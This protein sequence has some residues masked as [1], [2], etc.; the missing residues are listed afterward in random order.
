MA[1]FAVQML[2]QTPKPVPRGGADA[3]GNAEMLLAISSASSRDVE[4]DF[5][6]SFENMMEGKCPTGWTCSGPA[7]VCFPG[8]SS[9]PC[10]PYPGIKGH[11]GKQFLDVGNDFGTATAL[12]PMFKLP[13]DIDRICF[14]RC[15]GADEGS[16]LYLNLVSNGEQI[17]IAENGQD[18]DVFSVQCC[19][20]LAQHAGKEV[21]IHIR[22]AQSSGWGKVLIDDIRLLDSSGRDIGPKAP[23]RPQQSCG[24]VQEDVHY[25]GVTSL[26]SSMTL[27]AEDCCALCEKEPRCGAWAW[28]KIKNNWLTNKCFLKEL[29]PG[30]VPKQ[31]TWDGVVSGLPVK[32][33]RLI[34]APLFR[35]TEYKEQQGAAFTPGDEI[36]LYGIGSS[37]MLW[38]NWL[39]ELH[40]VLSRLGY[41][42]PAV[43]AKVKPEFH[44]RSVQTCDDSMYFEHLRTARFAR[45]GWCSWDFAFEGWNDCGND[46]Y[47]VIGGQRV[48]CQHGPGCGYSKHPAYASKFA[49]DA[50]RSDI[51]LVATWFNDD[52][53]RWSKYKCFEGHTIEKVAS[54]ALSIPSLLQTVRA[55]HAANPKV[56]VVV[57]GK[58]PQVWGHY[59]YGW[60]TEVNRVVREALASEPRTLF[61]DYYMPPDNVTHM[62]QQA[63]PGHPNCR[64]SRLITMAVLRR[65]Y[66]E[67]IIG[68]SLLLK[69]PTEKNLVHH[70]CKT[71]TSEECHTSVTC[72]VDPADNM[73]KEYSKGSSTAHPIK[74]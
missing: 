6:V 14:R 69:E 20:D 68:R 67:K 16:G 48:K 71:L 15:G 62:Y 59:T 38:M 30:V 42:L 39:E 66:E 63:H 22:D 64:G 29:K 58:Y 51:T 17:C 3:Q 11:D 46:G 33:L 47:R 8:S 34:K 61:I 7:A 43:D 2:Q 41:R 57:L 28:G 26:D 56:W 49:E 32:T 55:I 23:K 70:S 45:I 9:G 50:A 13:G 44:P 12:S 31:A 1:V 24:L 40:L 65:L 5:P 35:V 4:L 25:D 52:Q 53:Q 36:R 21:V 19:P 10:R 60:F 18:V 74:I 37:S 54:T 73:C 27:S 72:W